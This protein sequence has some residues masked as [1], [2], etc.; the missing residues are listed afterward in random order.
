VLV[1]RE[2]MARAV[3]AE[4]VGTAL[5]VAVVV[6]TNLMFELPAVEWSTPARSGSGLW[7]G[8]VVATPHG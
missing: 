8:E 5:L 4:G 1:T 6:V 2:A 3:V 7:L